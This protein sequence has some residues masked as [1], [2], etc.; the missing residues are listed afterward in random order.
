MWNA[1]NLVQVWIHIMLFI[2]NEN[3]HRTTSTYLIRGSLNKF[4]DSFRMGTFIDGT[5][6]KL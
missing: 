6:M 4:V 1:N 5:H 3:D 2:L